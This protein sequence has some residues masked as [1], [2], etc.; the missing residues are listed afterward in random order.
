MSIIVNWFHGT[1]RCFSNSSFYLLLREVCEVSLAQWQS[2]E[3]LQCPEDPDAKGKC[4][5]EW[6]QPEIGERASHIF[7]LT[8]HNFANVEAIVFSE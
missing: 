1:F 6:Q 2:V 5:K 3:S 8:T 7:S 4:T